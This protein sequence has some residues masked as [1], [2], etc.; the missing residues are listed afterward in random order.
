MKWAIGIDIGGTKTNIGCIDAAGNIL[1][2]IQIPTDTSE[3]FEDIIQEIATEI[4]LLSQGLNAPQGI[5]VGIAG[6]IDAITGDV[7]FA[8][9]LRWKNVPLKKQLEKSVQH[10]VRVINDV[11]AATLGEWLHGAGKGMNNLVCLFIG[12]GI[13]GGV[14]C[15]GQLLLGSNNSAAEV[16]HMTVDINGPKCSCGS[17]G[18]FEA[19]AGGW[20]IA[21]RAEEAHFQEEAL[22]SPVTAKEVIEA[23]HQGNAIASQIIDN[24]K[25][26][27]IFG[28]KNLINVF[29]PERLIIGGGVYR[30]LPEILNWMKEGVRQQALP[31][32]SEKL[33]ILPGVLGNDAG[34]VGAASLLLGRESS[35]FEMD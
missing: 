4:K 29:N 33:T 20:G 31:A 15:E 11:R 24:A 27:Y 1:R 9:N 25:K 3:K 14:V 35:S 30:G 13:G 17:Y 26:A 23:F 5:G 7:F 34:M 10:P 28:A 32:A 12:T 8:P 2:K 6:Q 21:K 19:I 16:G 18:C 22:A